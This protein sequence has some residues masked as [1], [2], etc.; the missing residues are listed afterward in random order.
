MVAERGSHSSS[1]LAPRP[2]IQSNRC[3]TATASSE[4][5][6]EMKKSRAATAAKANDPSTARMA[7]P[8]ARVSPIRRP[9][10]W[11]NRAPAS[12]RAMM[13]QR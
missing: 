12:G 5:S 6:A 2:G 9:N 11:L 7:G 13:I 4:A 3:T 1:A 10:M 8:D